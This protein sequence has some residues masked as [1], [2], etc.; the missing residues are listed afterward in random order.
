MKH[1]KQAVLPLLFMGLLVS[2]NQSNKSANEI[3]D[4]TTVIENS[5]PGPEPEYEPE[6]IQEEKCPT[7]NGTQYITCEK[8]NGEGFIVNE[9]NPVDKKTGYGRACFECNGSGYGF[10]DEHGDYPLKKGLGKVL[11]PTCVTEVN[12]E[13]PESQSIAQQEV[14]PDFENTLIGTH[15][16][17]L[18]WFDGKRGEV[19]LEKINEGVYSCKGKAYRGDDSLSI[20]GTI[21]VVKEDHLLFEGTIT[22]R[23]H[24]I[25]KGRPYHRTGKMDFVKNKGRKF[26]RLQ[27]MENGE[28]ID[29]VD[30]Y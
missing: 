16:L 12:I 23:V 29:Y 27:Q 19:N 13:F 5:E 2:C 26:W 22:C 7:C 4:S 25:Y 20:N 11:C 14:N 10:K 9:D 18:Q 28:C 30:I 15:K 24:H 3:N 8:C 1:L 17:E 6:P 21:Q